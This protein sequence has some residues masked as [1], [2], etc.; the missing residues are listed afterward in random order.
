MSR[1]G[2]KVINLPANTE[3]RVDGPVVIVKGPL[4]ELRK[5]ILPNVE[6][7]SE[8]NTVTFLKKRNDILSK[9]LWGT[10][11]SH[12]T[13]MIE[14]VNKPY[15]KKLSVEGVGYKSEV[16]GNNLVL[17]VGFSHPV[18]V[19]VPGGLKVTAEKNQ[20]TITGIDKEEVGSFA[21][22]VRSIKKPEPYKGKG[23]RYVGEV[24][25]MKQGKKTA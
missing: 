7:K 14:G 11:A 6:V 18:K 1:I 16:S 17:S 19:L 22:K 4:G 21:S 23:I 3:V 20:I 8:N 10:Y 2:K 12:V 13:N 5:E 9:A 25:K 15:E 24:V